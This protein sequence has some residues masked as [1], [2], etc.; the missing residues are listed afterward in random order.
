MTRSQPN[1]RLHCGRFSAIGS[2]SLNRSGSR[3][4]SLKDGHLFH[5]KQMSQLCKV[6]GAFACYAVLSRLRQGTLSRD[7]PQ[8][9]RFAPWYLRSPARFFRYRRSRNMLLSSA[10]YRAGASSRTTTHSGNGP[11]PGFS[12]FGNNHAFDFPL[13]KRRGVSAPID[14]AVH[15]N[16]IFP[17][18]SVVPARQVRVL[19]H[20]GISA[21]REIVKENPDP[22][23]LYVSR[24]ASA[25]GE[26]SR[27]RIIANTTTVGHLPVAEPH[28]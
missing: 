6:L 9:A 20:V 3:S 4:H 23:G 11:A 7:C 1:A 18:L 26:G 13:T 21:C 10:E 12:G 24:L 28:S 19:Q 2:D 8:R 5:A 15:S 14:Q 17:S 16:V 22:R 25:K 27:C